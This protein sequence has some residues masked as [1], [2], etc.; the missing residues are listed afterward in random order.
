VVLTATGVEFAYGAESGEAGFHLV[1]PELEVRAGEVLA[2]CGPSG[3]GKSTLL[4]ILA[5]LKRPD[6]GRVRAL[7]EGGLVDCYEC[8]AKEWRRRRRHFGFVHQ[9]A[10]EHLN[11]LRAVVDSVADPLNIHGLLRGRSERRTAA[12]ALLQKVGLTAEQAGRRPGAL[13][14]GQQQRV[15]LARALATQPGL[16]FLDE[17]TSALDVSV[18]AGVVAL[19]QALRGEN[20]DRAYVLVTHDLGLVRQ[21]ADRVAVLDAGRLIELGAVDEVFARPAAE[22]TRTLLELSRGG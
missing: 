15:A 17:P 12:L 5:G 8:S 2:L 3:S 1:V 9:D 14:G 6:A 4:A 22:V 10:L 18:Q 7:I 13:S 21:L 20:A 19:L 16:V 11:D